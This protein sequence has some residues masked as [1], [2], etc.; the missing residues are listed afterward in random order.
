MLDTENLHATQEDDA[1][2]DRDDHEDRLSVV[3]SR[4]VDAVPVYFFLKQK[5]GII[6]TCPFVVSKKIPAKKG[7]SF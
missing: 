1:C 7:D 4:L 2:H 5:R 6:F 3:A